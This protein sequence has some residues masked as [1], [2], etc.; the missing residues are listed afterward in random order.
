[1]LHVELAGTLRQV[2]G[3]QVKGDKGR[4][5]SFEVSVNGELIYSKL[6]TGTFPD[7]EQVSVS[8]SAD[9]SLRN[10]SVHY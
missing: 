9:W 10:C 3:V 8:F 7:T 5:N 1:L 2:P 6:E 4:P